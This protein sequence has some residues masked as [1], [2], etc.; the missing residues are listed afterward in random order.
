MHRSRPARRTTGPRPRPPGTGH[1]SPSRHHRGRTRRA[2]WTEPF[3]EA[4]PHLRRNRRADEQANRVV[5]LVPT[6]LG[7]DQR[8]Q[9]VPRVGHHG[10][11]VAAHLGPERLRVEPV[12][13]G[14]SRP[15]GADPTSV[16]RSRSPQI[17]ATGTCSSPD[18]RDRRSR[19]SAVRPGTAQ[20]FAVPR[21]F[22]MRRARAWCAARA[23]T[24]AGACVPGP[25]SD[26]DCRIPAW[27][28]ARQRITRDTG[29]KVYN[30]RTTAGRSR[31]RRYGPTTA[32]A[33]GR[34]STSA[35]TAQTC[36]VVTA[37]ICISV[38]EMLRWLP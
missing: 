20:R 6:R 19:G 21:R 28:A 24:C 37:S 7:I 8:R 14:E 38:S 2:H 5:A 32:T 35:A 25:R 4:V 18:D 34:L 30:R 1:R 15:G 22:C 23:T 9:H 13:E 10:R 26:S 17:S 12:G 27:P 11:P 3:D 29:T 16:S 31:W 36:S 33:A